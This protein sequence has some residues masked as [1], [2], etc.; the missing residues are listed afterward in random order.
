M[1]EFQC[2]HKAA[3]GA[4]MDRPRVRQVLAQGALDVQAV[5][6]VHE[7]GDEWLARGQPQ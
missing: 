5:G 7:P 6:V 3:V 1:A 2:S 4:G